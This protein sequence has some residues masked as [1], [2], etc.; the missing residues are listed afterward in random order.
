M[1]ERDI[2][3]R[4]KLWKLSDKFGVIERQPFENISLISNL[5]R[6]DIREPIKFAQ[7]QNSD[8]YGKPDYQFYRSEPNSLDISFQAPPSF[9]S[10]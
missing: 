3:Q 4:K 10:A 8:N 7:K 1:H 6:E 2:T 9:K 5:P